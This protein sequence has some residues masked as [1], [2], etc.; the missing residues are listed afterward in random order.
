[1]TGSIITHKHATRTKTFVSP[2]RDAR[3]L[4]FVRSRTTRHVKHN[5][6][7]RSPSN[8]AR[9]D[10]IKNSNE[11]MTSNFRTP[12]Q[13]N[14]RFA[15]ITTNRRKRSCT[16]C[17]HT[18]KLVQS[19]FVFLTKCKRKNKKVSFTRALHSLWSVT[20]GLRRPSPLTLRRGPRGY[21]RSEC[22]TGG[23]SM[24]ARKHNCL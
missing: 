12:T 14:Q 6:L 13:R 9:V 4:F 24:A 18:A 2:N 16:W 3:R 23:E 19:K 5:V 20:S 15:A 1:M 8:I 7:H 10:L 11:V 22:C 21:F 17:H